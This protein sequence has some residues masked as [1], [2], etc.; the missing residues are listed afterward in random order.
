MLKRNAQESKMICT[1]SEQEL[2]YLTVKVQFNVVVVVV[3]VIFFLVMGRLDR[4]VFSDFI[5]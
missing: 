2:L 1:D 4:S 3:V 5:D